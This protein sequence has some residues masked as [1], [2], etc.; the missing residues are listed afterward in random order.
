MP[1]SAPPTRGW[2]NWHWSNHNDYLALASEVYRK[3]AREFTGPPDAFV[4]QPAAR[5]A[6]RVTFG[7][8]ADFPDLFVAGV[9]RSGGRSFPPGEAGAEPYDL[10]RVFRTRGETAPD[11]G[12]PGHIPRLEVRARLV[13]S[14]RL[15][16]RP[17]HRHRR[18]LVDHLFEVI[19]VHR[20]RLDAATIIVSR[21]AVHQGRVR[22]G[23]IVRLR[24]EPWHLHPERKGIPRRIIENGTSPP[25]PRFVEVP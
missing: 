7:T 24:L 12:P 10:A 19:E 11:P 17:A 13:R 9:P 25:P 22:P 1:V 8:H 21:R 2:H 16:L 6:T 5:R 23:R 20:G 15:D 18:L 3:P 4:L 14:A